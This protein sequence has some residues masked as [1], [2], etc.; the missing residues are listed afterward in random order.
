MGGTEEISLEDFMSDSDFSDA[1]EFKDF[2]SST[3]TEKSDILNDPPIDMSLSFDDSFVLETKA[4]PEDDIE[5]D[6]PVTQDFLSDIVTT[7]EETFDN[8]DDIFDNITDMNTPAEPEIK[9]E[10]IKPDLTTFSILS[11][12]LREQRM[13][14]S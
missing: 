2:I 14:L 10:E 13:K 7:G 9:Q 11:K 6:I 1:S 5:T 12:S 3:T 8:F 4:N